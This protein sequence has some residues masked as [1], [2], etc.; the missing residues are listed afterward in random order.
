MLSPRRVLRA[1]RQS[2]GG[3]E[4]CWA[5]AATAAS[6]AVAPVCLAGG[7]HVSLSGMLHGLLCCVEL[8][9]ITP[10]SLPA[11]A[12]DLGQASGGPLG[13]LL[14]FL[15]ADK[16][17]RKENWHNRLARRAVTSQRA[18]ACFSVVS[19]RRQH[20][21]LHVI[22]WQVNKQALAGWLCLC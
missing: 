21:I 17:K 6:L 8:P 11:A 3:T 18:V 14:L 20:R 7:A 10:A 12:C 1:P 15:W 13:I 22:S 9:P 2:D 4:R 5:A 16:L 19:S